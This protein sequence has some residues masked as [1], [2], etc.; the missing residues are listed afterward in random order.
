[1]YIPVVYDL[2]VFKFFNVCNTTVL[3]FFDISNDMST[4]LSPGLRKLSY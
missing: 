3:R 1:M 4:I 2:T